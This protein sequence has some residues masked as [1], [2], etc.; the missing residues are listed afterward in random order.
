M[1]GYGETDTED[2][3]N[4][5]DETDEED[6]VERYDETDTEDVM[7]DGYD[8]YYNQYYERDWRSVVVLLQL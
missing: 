3:I 7:S 1:E 8:E 4:E 5:Y 2:V 6:W